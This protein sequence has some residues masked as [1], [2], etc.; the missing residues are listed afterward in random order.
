GRAIDALA[1]EDWFATHPYVSSGSSRS[2]FYVLNFTNL[3]STDHTLEHWYNLTET[4]YDA[5]TTRDFW[6]LEWDNALNQHVCFPYSAFTCR[7]RLFFIDASAFNWYLTWAR[8]W[9]EI[10]PYLI[11]PKYD[12]YFEDL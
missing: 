9:W 4:E 3:D 5:I 2:T 12:Y 6:R 1:V 7:H 11:D 8:I 10:T